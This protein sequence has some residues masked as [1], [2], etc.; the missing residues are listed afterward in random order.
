MSYLN[1]RVLDNVK[2]NCKNLFLEN[3]FSS[4]DQLKQYL[5]KFILKILKHEKILFKV[6]KYLKSDKSNKNILLDNDF[7]FIN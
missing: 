5:L 6:C 4:C 1:I 2:L 7:S 3:F